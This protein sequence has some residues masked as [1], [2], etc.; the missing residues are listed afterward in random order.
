GSA[1]PSADQSGPFR[2]GHCL[3]V[4]IILVPACPGFLAIAAHFA[5]A[6]LGE[7]LPLTWLFQVPVLLAN[8]PAHVE[9]CQVTGSE[10]SHRHSE[11][12]PRLVDRFD[13][14]S[15]FY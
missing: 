14:C 13:P 6:V 12:V 3:A 9:P 15:F 1:S 5:Q 8:P 11:V 4:L 10:R 2:I 7:R